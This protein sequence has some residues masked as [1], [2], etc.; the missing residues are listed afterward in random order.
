MFFGKNSEIYQLRARL[1]REKRHKLPI[2]GGKEVVSLDVLHT[3]QGQD[4]VWTT[5]CQPTWK[6]MDA[7]LE[8]HEMLKLPHG[9]KQLICIAHVHSYNLLLTLLPSRKSGPVWAPLRHLPRHEE[10]NE[11]GFYANSS[12]RKPEKAGILLIHFMR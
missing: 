12:F 10:R 6:Q 2:G 3:L 5:S 8:G 7:F 9:K 11:C 4:R 1:I